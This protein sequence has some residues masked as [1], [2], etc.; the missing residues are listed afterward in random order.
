MS[1]LCNTWALSEVD[2]CH[3]WEENVLFKKCFRRAH[4]CKLHFRL[5]LV[6]QC[7]QVGRYKYRSRTMG[8]AKHGQG[9]DCSDAVTLL[10]VN[11]VRDLYYNNRDVAK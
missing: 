5:W 6:G 2:I 8:Q 10:F 9:A 1:Y 3:H 4:R 7:M 11:N